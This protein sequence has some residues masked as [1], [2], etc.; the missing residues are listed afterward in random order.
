MNDLNNI[1]KNNTKVLPV[2][3]CGGTGTRLWPLSRQSFPKQFLNINNL[4]E[5]S[6][7]QNTL[8]RLEGI[9]DLIEPILICNSEHRFVV[10]EQMREINTNPKSIL[11]EPFGRSTAP[12]ILLAA[13]KSLETEDNPHLLILSADHQIKNDKKFR[14]LVEFGKNYSKDNK[15]VTFGV[16]P[17]HP[18]TGYGYIKSEKP[19]NKKILEGLNISKFIEKP[20]FD[21]AKE[22][23]KD[24]TYTWNSGI[25]MFKA[26]TIINEMRE[27]CPDIFDICKKTFVESEYDLDFQRL[28]EKSFKNCPNIS[29]D[30]AV[31]EKTKK[32]IVIPLDA[33]WSDIGSWKSLWESSDKDKNGNITN[34]NVLVEKTYNSYLRSDKRLL[35]SLGINNL[36]IIDTDD[37][38]LVADKNESENIKKMVKNLQSRNFSEAVSHKKVFRPWGFYMSI[39]EGKRFQVKILHVKPD[40]KLSLQMHHHRAEHWVVVK[41]TAEVNIE[42]EIK[43]LSEN[44]STFIPLGAKHRLSNPGKIPLE[45]IEVQ[46][47]SYVGEDDIVRFKDKYGR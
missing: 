14:E 1:T 3:L 39:T 10:A 24:A 42:D 22:L 45:I 7:L 37:V 31:M 4:N 36:I 29:I 46:S 30:N 43:I 35:V 18:E 21:R 2:I 15:L 12:A 8:L 6:L 9:E 11:L 33:D 41:G 27:L 16:V 17:R 5:K 25:F 34:G 23:I 20:N 47:G 40:A 44:E 19:F 26:Q 13:F 28:N 32:G 38:T